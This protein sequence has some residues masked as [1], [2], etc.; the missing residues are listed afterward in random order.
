MYRNALRSR[1]MSRSA[2]GYEMP[3]ETFPISEN[4]NATR[5]TGV[6]T[7]PLENHIMQCACSKEIKKI[8]LIMLMTF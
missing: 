7:K 6:F 3:K 2:A 4:V 5:W 8:S 1:S